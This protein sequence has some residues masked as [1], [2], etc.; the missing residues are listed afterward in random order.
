MRCPVE[1]PAPA[2]H[3]IHDL[4]ARRWS[5]RAFA[6]RS[7][8]PAVLR[9]L[10]EAARWAP[11]SFNEQ[12]WGF[13]VA[14]KEDATAFARLFGLLVEGNQAWAKDAAALMVSVARATFTLNGKPNRHAFHDVGM[15]S[16]NLALEATARGVAVHFMAGFKVEEARVALGLPAGVD[17]VA[18]AALGYPGDAASLPSPLKEREAAPRT[19]RGLAEFVFQDAYGQVSPLVAAPR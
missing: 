17:P 14:R 3:P 12:P 10:L 19:R 4:L 11:S 2:D 18:A 13:V 15:A 16:E 8:E 6:P 9:S 5:P 1:K 7:L